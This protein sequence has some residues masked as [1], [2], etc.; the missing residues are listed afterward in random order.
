MNTVT[1]KQTGYGQWKASTIYYGKVIS[2]HF[3][4][5]PTYDRIKNQEKGYKTTL[6]F[7]VKKIINQHKHGI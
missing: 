3:T 7:L 6:K 1:F 4:D 2:I 5:A